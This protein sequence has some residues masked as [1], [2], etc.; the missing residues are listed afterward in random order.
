MILND[1]IRPHMTSK[2]EQ[3]PILTAND[4]LISGRDRETERI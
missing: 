2:D 4:P 1:P 3:S